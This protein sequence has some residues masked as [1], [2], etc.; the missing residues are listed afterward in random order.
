[1]KP[2][3][4]ESF[5]KKLLPCWASVLLSYPV[6]ACGPDNRMLLQWGRGAK[7][8]VLDLSTGRELS[9]GVIHRIFTGYPQ[10][11]AE[12]DLSTGLSTELFIL[13]STASKT[14]VKASRIV[15][16]MLPMS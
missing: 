14:Y 12:I 13:I 9:T 3:A 5:W 6:L 4:A 11:A 15:F 8:H 7:N 2:S 1:M 16:Y 10:A